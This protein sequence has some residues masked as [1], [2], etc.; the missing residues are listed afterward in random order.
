MYLVNPVRKIFLLGVFLLLS[1]LAATAQLHVWL[2]LD[3]KDL[4][5]KEFKQLPGAE[6]VLLYY[7][8]EIDDVSHTEFFYSRIKVLTDSGKRHANVE[9]PIT[10]KTSVMELAART[11]HPDGKIVDLASQ[12]FEKV[13]FQGKGLRIR[14]QTFTLPQVSAGDIIEYR[15]EL[16]YGD[17]GLR[18]HHW[19]V[20][21]DLYALKEHFWFRYDKKYSVK[22]LPTAGLQ[23]S[24]DHDAKAGILQMN[25][26]NV[27]P[28]EAE[29]QMPPEDGYKLEIKFF[30]TT[31]FM[32][33]P[34]S[35][36]L[37]TGRWWSEGINYFLGN[38]KEIAS[39]AAETIGSETDPDK[40]LRKLY[41]RAQEIRNLSFERR[42]T[43]KEQKKEELKPPKTIVDVLRHGYGD[44]NDVTMLFVA[45]ARGAGFTSSVAFVSS[46]ESRLFDREVMSFSQLDSEIAVVRLNGKRVFLDPGTRY[47]PYGTLRWFRTGTAAMDMSDPGGLI[48]TPGAADDGA[49]ISR[50]AELKLGPDGAAKGEVRIEYSGAEALERR[51]SAL[52]TDEAGRKKELEDEVKLW[53]PANAKVEMTDSVAWDK[54]YEP[55]TAVFKVDVPE[56]ASAAGKRLLIPTALFL[57]KVKRVLKSGPRKYPIYYHYA[58]TEIDALSLEVPEGYSAETLAAPQTMTTKLGSYSSSATTTGKR[59]TLERSLKVKGMYF[60]PDLYNELRD[61][62]V[63]VQAGDELQ[64]VLRQAPTAEAQKAN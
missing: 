64:T 61:F 19:T 31:P 34:S 36:W 63:K 59:V 6:A 12:P 48:S 39:A 56:F 3:S 14:V 16:H 44:R 38:H 22:W 5:M 21:H 27:S 13:V 62:F 15:Y 10:D 29:E 52:E 58:F 25:S 11:I 33:S 57:P 49:I 26:E 55:L 35:Y 51:L 40:K 50:S 32:S 47:C 53:L 60:Q 28:F 46:R 37:E 42:R 2:P 4:Q 45:M 1:A 17:K 43:E 9:I 7:Q 41:A 18:H 20:Q 30:Y 54:E 24:P 8:N 23:Q